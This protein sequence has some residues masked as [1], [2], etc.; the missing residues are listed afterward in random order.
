M[1]FRRGSLNGIPRMTV[2]PQ[3]RLGTWEDAI[4]DTSTSHMSL[5]MRSY[6]RF[7]YTKFE[8]AKLVFLKTHK[9][10]ACLEK[11]SRGA[12]WDTCVLPFTE[13]LHRTRGP[14]RTL[15]RFYQAMCTENCD[16]F[17]PCRWSSGFQLLTRMRYHPE[18]SSDTYWTQKIATSPWLRTT[19]AYP[20]NAFPQLLRVGPWDSGKKSCSTDLWLV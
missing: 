3:S 9:E 14:A 13:G 7:H 6:S 17:H 5:S 4:L 11:T 20:C 16:L 8:E 19:V 12:S 10:N 2:T 1:S 15:H 18:V